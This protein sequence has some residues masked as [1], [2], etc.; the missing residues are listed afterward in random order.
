MDRTNT[1]FRREW[2]FHL[3]KSR[4]HPSKPIS[5]RS[6]FN[7]SFMSLRTKPWEWSTFG[8]AWKI[9]PVHQKHTQMWGVNA[10]ITNKS[11]LLAVWVLA[12]IQAQGIWKRE[13][14][15]YH[16][17]DFPVLGS[18]GHHKQLLQDPMQACHQKYSKLHLGS[19]TSNQIYYFQ[20]HL[21]MVSKSILFIQRSCNSTGL[22]ERPRD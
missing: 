1:K 16:L 17:K 9:S 22:E 13:I 14:F 3:T 11:F 7:H 4:R 18:L 21:C 15:F 6:Q 2:H 12:Q 20:N 5:F 19:T 10:F 8:A